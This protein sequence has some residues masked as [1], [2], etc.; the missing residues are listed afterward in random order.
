MIGNS[1]AGFL[2]TGVAVSASSFESIATATGTGSSGTITFSS[3][4]G[5]YSAL[6]IRVNAVASAVAAL[7][8]TVNGDTAANY[9]QHGLYGNGTAASASGAPSTSN[10]SILGGLDATITTYP[11]VAIIDILDYASTT[12]NKTVRSFGGFD[13]N[14]SGSDVCL[15]SGV[16]RSTSAITS[17]SLAM[18]TGNF[19]TSTTIALYGVKA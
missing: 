8:M 15:M 12:K 7:Q 5:T 1:I 9:T 13:K 17:V 11:N 6:Q 3:I 18:S 16:W 19:T 4:A 10:I 14:A 2:G